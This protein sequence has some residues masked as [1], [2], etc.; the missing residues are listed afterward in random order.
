MAWKKIL[1]EGDAASLSDTTPQAVDGT[2]EAAG[3]GTDASRDDHVHALGPLTG[4]LDFNQ[5]QAIGMVL[6]ATDTPPDAATEVEGQVYY[7]SG[8]ADRHPYIWD[9]TEWKKILLTGD[10]SALSDANPDQIGTTLSAGTNT[11]ASRDDHVHTIGTGA[12]DTSNMFASGIVDA[13]AIGSNEVTPT[14]LQDTG[15]FTMA[16]LTFSG[17]ATDGAMLV[18]P[19]SEPTS[20]AEGTVYYDS[21]AVHLYVY[22]A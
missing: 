11:L 13:T 8:G 7:D 17:D 12:I 5:N 20:T 21:T 3:S 2:A 14:E 10:A 4:T 15:K 9:T 19:Q 16:Q 18:T 1:L 22:V 6:H